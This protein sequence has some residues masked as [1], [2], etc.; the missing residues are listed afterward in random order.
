VALSSDDGASSIDDGALR[1]DDRALSI[2][3]G[4][5]PFDDAAL[6]FGK[7]ARIEAGMTLTDGNQAGTLAET[8]RLLLSG[9]SK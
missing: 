2:D 3:E 4:A 6:S 7:M 9:W 1:D 8:G 5:L